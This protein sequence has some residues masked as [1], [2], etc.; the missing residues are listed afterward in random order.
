MLRP[1]NNSSSSSGG[2]NRQIRGASS[3]TNTALQHQ[4]QAGPRTLDHVTAA[5]GALRNWGGAGGGDGG[6]AWAVWGPGLG[7]RGHWRCPGRPLLGRSTGTHTTVL[8]VFCLPHHVA[9]R[10]LKD[11]A[12]RKRH[13]IHLFDLGYATRRRHRREITTGAALSALAISSSATKSLAFQ[14]LL[15]LPPIS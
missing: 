2:G 15:P 10:S 13:F 11:G 8:G 7:G 14:K 1:R 12:K 9:L 6:G 4:L 5:G 3:M